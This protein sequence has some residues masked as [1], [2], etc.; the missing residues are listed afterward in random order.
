MNT[1]PYILTD[2][3]LT[4]FDSVRPLTIHRGNVGDHMWSKAMDAL[5]AGDFDA[6]KQMADV[7][8]RL[9]DYIAND[10][11]A[12]KDGYL[13]Y[14]GEM[15]DTYPAR[16]AVELMN[17]GLPFEPLLRF[18]ERLERNPS[19][20]AVQDLYQFLEHGKMPLTP[21]GCFLAYKKVCRTAE[22]QFVDCYSRSIRNNVGDVVSMPRNRVDE[23]P[24][25]TCS[26][27]L[28]VCSFEYLPYFGAGS[29]DNVVVC[30][31]D[32]ADVVAIPRDYNNTKMRV[33]RYE[34]V[35]QVPHEQF[36][37]VWKDTPVVEDYNWRP[38]DDS[39]GDPW[40]EELGPDDLVE[41][42][43]RDGDTFRGRVEKDIVWH[44]DGD[45]DDV[46]AYRLVARGNTDEDGNI[47]EDHCEFCGEYKSECIC[48]G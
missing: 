3:T 14:K 22:G 38:W 37:H 10:N 31:I 32:P 25:Q 42:R 23:N 29:W 43:L 2:E 30:K 7:S 5:K 6:I 12:V 20:R 28:H 45:M 9:K 27:G 40:P 18:I 36:R 48:V 13:Y 41:V 19:R 17:N 8:T 4:L 34:V 15:L 39:T 33:C 1:M 47:V 26:T 21:D 24:D 44:H 16:K 46:I 11:F 35:G